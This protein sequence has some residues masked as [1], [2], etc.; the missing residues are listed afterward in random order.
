MKPAEKD[1]LTAFDLD[2]RIRDR[3]LAKGEVDAKVLERHLAELPDLEPQ[4]ET[5]PIDQPALGEGEPLDDQPVGS[6]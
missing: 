5:I 1:K 3:K 2:L 4:A 6:A